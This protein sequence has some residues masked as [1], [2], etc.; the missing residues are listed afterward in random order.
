MNDFP[1]LKFISDVSKN[2]LWQVSNSSLLGI[3][4]G[5]TKTI[6]DIHINSKLSNETLYFL[7]VKSFL[8]TLELD[9]SDVEKFMKENPSHIRL[10]FEIFKILEN[11]TL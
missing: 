9:E 10:G 11:T 1:L 6:S 5:L 8:D 2:I 3:P 4:E 7:Q